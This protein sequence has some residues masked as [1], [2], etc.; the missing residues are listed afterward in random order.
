MVDNWRKKEN[1]IKKIIYQTD[2]K[3]E[4][5]LKAVEEKKEEL[6]GLISDEGALFIIA[7]ELGV[8]V[9][10]SSENLD[11]SAV[12]IS[13]LKEDMKNINV[14]GRIKEIY[15]EF[16]FTNKYGEI[17]SVGSFLLHDKTGDIRVVVWDQHVR[18]F[19]NRDFK[20]NQL[21][22]VVNA[23]TKIDERKR[24]EIHVGRLAKLIFSPDDVDPNEYPGIGEN[25][26]DIA[27]L[28]EKKMLQYQISVKGKI[29][30]KFPVKKY[31]TQKERIGYVSTIILTDSSGTIR[32]T[33]WD[34]EIDKISP[35]NIGDYIYITNLSKH[36]NKIDQI[37]IELYATKITKIEKVVKE[38]EDQIQFAENISSLQD[39]DNLVSIKGVISSVENLKKVKLKSGEEREVLNFVVSDDTD[40]IRVT[41]WGDIGKNFHNII[42][43]GSGITIKDILLKFNDYTGRKELTSTNRT[44]IKVYY[45]KD[46]P[47]W[48]QPL[49]IKHY[50]NF[51]QISSIASRGH[52]VIKGFIAANIRKI[53]FYEGCT[54]CFKKVENCICGSNDTIHRMVVNVIIDDQS[55]TINSA[56]MGIVA[57]KLLNSDTNILL[58][59][60]DRP[61]FQSVLANKSREL[62]GKEIIIVGE[63][64]FNDYSNSYEFIVRDFQNANITSE[65]DELLSNIEQ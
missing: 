62:F 63:A 58:K 25:L 60:K 41:L 44:E 16:E 54:K 65:L 29:T 6:K 26:I 23:F 56:F 43:S 45:I 27:K 39:L 32:I 24:L 64:R 46:V 10:Y 12:N 35:L 28:K 20:I 57:E 40:G 31:T 5:I 61:N 59:M 4:E 49:S 9:K 51:T 7:K 34:E 2:L 17:G 47:M 13:L 30:Q 50:T 19:Q 48:E 1:Y 18:I 55:G 42:K 38:K 36:I 22:K 52:Y 33:F 11:I 14:V 37:S 21:V 3:R 15:K 8:D 53:Y